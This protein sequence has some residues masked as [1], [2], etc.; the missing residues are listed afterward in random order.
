MAT[1]VAVDLGAHS[2][3][4]AL[5]RFD[6]ER[7]SVSELH[8]FPNLPVRTRGTLEWDVLRLYSDVLDGLRRAAGE[9]RID[10]VAVDSWAVDFGLLDARGRLIRNPTHYRDARRATAVDEVLER[11]PARELYERTGIQLLPIN[12]VFE[13][14]AMTIDDDPALRIAQRLLLIP[15][16]F[17]YWLAGTGTTEYTN[18]TTTQCLD[19]SGTWARDLLGRLEIDA[20]LFG[21]I[22]AAGTR[23]GPL[24]PDVAED[25]GLG[26]AEVIATATHDT[27]A[28]VAAVPFDRSD[29]AFISAGT[30]SLVG[31]ELAEPLIDEHTFAANLTNEGG[32]GGTTR[33][34]RNVTGLWLLE[35]SRRAWGLPGSAV[36]DLVDLA[37]HAVALHALVDVD[38]P[39]FAPPGDMPQRVRE[40]CAGT[41]QVIPED[42]GAVVRCI[43]ESVAAKHAFAIER[44]RAATGVA[45]SAV[46]IVGGGSQND[47]LCQMTADATG[48]PVIAGPTEATEIGNLL[49]QA[50]A[51]DEIGSLEQARAVVRASFESRVYEPGSSDGWLEARERVERSV[52]LNRDAEVTA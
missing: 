8:R 40:F 5:G 24:A 3:R 49:V 4:V 47:L 16:L 7:L 38:D 23:L 9:D 51:L 29:A 33:L 30:W 50:I 14:G 44:L 37:R 32:V 2:G 6:G 13:L 15:D 43:L 31:L 46:H 1:M 20:A 52:V 27:A 34:L 25:T 22:V 45:V 41:K 42:R 26:K 10:S 11:I 12:T 48:L 21:E 36:S 17:H 18:A 39:L 19:R 35:E 28:A